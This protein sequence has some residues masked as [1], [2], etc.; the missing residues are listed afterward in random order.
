[1]P[2]EN[3]PGKSPAKS[4]QIYTTKFP[5]TFLQRVGANRDTKIFFAFFLC[6]PRRPNGMA[7]GVVAMGFISCLVS[8]PNM[9]GRPGTCRTVEMNR[10]SSASYL[11]CT[12]SVFCTLFHRGG[13]RRAFRLPG[14]ERGSFPLCGGTF[15]RSYPACDPTHFLR[16]A[17]EFL[18]IPGPRFWESCDSRFAILCC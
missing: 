9:S 6:N 10:G 3:P 4:S 8:L 7:G 5:D 1:M 18:A 14:G 16:L 15:A 11:A 13:K 2:R 17:V 12:L